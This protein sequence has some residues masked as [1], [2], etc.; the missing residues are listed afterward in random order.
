[1]DLEN[2]P[3][4]VIGHRVGLH[5]DVN[6]KGMT[7]G[8]VGIDEERWV[9]G[10]VIGMNESYMSIKLD[11]PIG[12]GEPSGLLKRASKGQDRIAIDDVDRIRVKQSP[13]TDGGGSVPQEIVDLAR[14]GDKLKAIKQYRA[15]TGATF[16]EAQAWLRTV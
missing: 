13:G 15:L 12:T 9:S 6:L 11:Q 4:G 7:V 1:M 5:L 10:V 8:G 14:A 2:K 3:L 16:E